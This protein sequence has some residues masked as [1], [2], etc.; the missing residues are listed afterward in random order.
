MY[1]LTGLPTNQNV[2]QPE[3]KMAAATPEG[4]F[5]QEASTTRLV[6]PVAAHPSLPLMPQA[7]SHHILILS[8]YLE[9]Y[10]QQPI[11]K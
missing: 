4:S 5:V 2:T 8:L 11:L 7:R 6:S 9:S 10:P 3:G 1:I